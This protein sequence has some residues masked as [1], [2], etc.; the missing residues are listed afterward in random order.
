MDRTKI[1]ARVLKL[2]FEPKRQAQEA[3]QNGGKN[4]QEI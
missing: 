2:K 4:W 3:V 1:T